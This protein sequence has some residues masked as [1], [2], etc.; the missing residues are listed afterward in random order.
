V[1]PGRHDRPHER[2]HRDADE[3]ATQGAS[4]RG[5]RPR[6]QRP[7]HQRDGVAEGQ[8]SRK[9][10]LYDHARRDGIG[11][12]LSVIGGKLTAYRAIA[13]EVADRV[14]RA[15]G[16]GGTGDTGDTRTAPLP[17]AGMPISARAAALGLPAT[18]AANLTAV[19]GSLAAGVLDLVAG[20]PSLAAPL[21]PH[22]PTIAAELAHVVKSEWAV[23]LGDALLR[24]TGFGLRACQG[25]DCV[26]AIAE[27]MGALCGWDAARRLREIDA[28]RRELAPMRAFSTG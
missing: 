15:L 27:R 24:R 20:D 4:H 19:Y 16:V 9:H 2:E 3:P 21:C 11:G 5:G 14:V 12:V 17:G 26:D 23:T 22:E 13:E 10:A 7:Q 8:V 18:V 25:L 1:Q 28:Y 6:R